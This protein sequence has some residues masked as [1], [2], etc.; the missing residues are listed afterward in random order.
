MYISCDHRS[1]NMWLW[2]L[3][4]PWIR[5]DADGHRPTVDT[6]MIYTEINACFLSHQ[7]VLAHTVSTGGTP[8]AA[9]AAVTVPWARPRDLA[10]GI[11]PGEKS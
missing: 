5:S 2:M 3:R 9:A 4:M 8:A 1:I 6:G 11:G 10:L 7:N